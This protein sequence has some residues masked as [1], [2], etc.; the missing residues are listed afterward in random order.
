MIYTVSCSVYELDVEF[1][2]LFEIQGEMN[3]KQ[4][5]ENGFSDMFVTYL[6]DGF[7]EQWEYVL[8][9]RIEVYHFLL[10]FHQSLK[11]EES[12]LLQA[13]IKEIQEHKKY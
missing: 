13:K 11:T 9:N 3:V 4:S 2:Y 12:T 6:K 7:P 1:N 5:M 10:V 8:Y